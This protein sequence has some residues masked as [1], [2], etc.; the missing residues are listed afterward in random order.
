MAAAKCMAD[1]SSSAVSESGK[2][3]IALPGGDTPRGLFELLAEDPFRSTLPWSKLHFFW[4]DER[5]VPKDHP[6]SNYKLASETFLSSV[7]IPESNLHLAPVEGGSPSQIAQAYEQ[8][9]RRFFQL[10]S[11]EFPQ[12]DLILLG[13]GDDGHTA[14][15]FPGGPELDVQSCLVTWSQ[16]D[17]FSP[18]R[19]T[20]TLETINQAKNVFFLVRGISKAAALGRVLDGDENLPAAKVKPIEGKLMFFVDEEALE[21]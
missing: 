16:P 17:P 11:G 12:F 18:S 20:F 9:I 3:V 10:E 19:V 13:I 6:E 2:C 8:E 4:G 5:C 21:S 7:A 14:S 1:L 15:L